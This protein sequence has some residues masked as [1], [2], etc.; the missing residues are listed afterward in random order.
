MNLIYSCHKYLILLTAFPIALGLTSVIS[1][2]Q[3]RCRI[4]NLRNPERFGSNRHYQWVGLVAS[5]IWSDRPD[6]ELILYL[7]HSSSYSR[8]GFKSIRCVSWKQGYS[9]HIWL[10]WIGRYRLLSGKIIPLSTC[11]QTV[12]I[13][14][15]CMCRMF[16]VRSIT[17][18]NR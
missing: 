11:A 4:S 3:L 14:I 12:S 13:H 1:H 5:K 10:S 17:E 7:T 6:R 9:G 16:L 2:L 18:R 15:S 8:M